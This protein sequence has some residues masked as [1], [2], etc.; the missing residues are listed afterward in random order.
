MRLEEERLIR[1]QKKKEKDEQHLYMSPKIISNEHFKEHQGF[2]LISWDPKEIVNST[3]PPKSYRI[4]K[5]TSVKDFVKI[6]A[7]DLQEPPEKVRLWV[8]VNRQN[9]T[10]RPD[11]PL[12]N[13]EMSKFLLL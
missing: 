11:N 13:L 3:M 1:E 12:T 5:S 10:V 4:L 7:E 9:K 2:D 8:M 6:V